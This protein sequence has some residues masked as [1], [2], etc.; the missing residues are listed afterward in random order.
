MTDFIRTE[1]SKMQQPNN[2]FLRARKEEVRSP[3]TQFLP[4]L[5]LLLNCNTL[6]R[7]MWKQHQTQ[8][9]KWRWVVACITRCA[10]DLHPSQPSFSARKLAWIYQ[11][12]PVTCGFPGG[13]AEEIG[14]AFKG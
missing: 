6:G 10:V 2:C 13:S 9:E 3:D 12:D 1:H 14:Q 11:W 4:L 5:M 8:R 7:S